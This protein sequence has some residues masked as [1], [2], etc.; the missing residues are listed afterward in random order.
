MKPSKF[1]VV[2]F[3][4]RNGVSSWR[5]SGWLNGDRIRKNFKNRAEAVAEKTTLEVRAAQTEQ[6]M[7]TVATTLTAEEVREAETVFHRLRGR[8]CPLSF[9]VDFALT[10][11]KEPEHRKKLVDAC[12]DYVAAKQR[13]FDQQQLSRSQMRHI[14]WETKRLAAQFPLLSVAEV[15]STALTAYLEASGG[16]MKNH[17]NRRGLLSTFFKFCFMRG[18]TA[19]NPIPKVPHYRIRR[20][21]GAATTLTAAH[22]RKV[23]DFAETY[24]GGALVPF[25]ALCLF[26]GIRPGVPEGEISR[27]T[28]EMVD[29]G[30]CEI[31]ITAE[32]SKVSEPRTTTIQPNLAAWL[33]AYPL[34]GCAVALG[35]FNKRRQA[36]WR[37]LG[38]TQDVMRHTFISMFVAKF[39]SIGEAAIQAGNS[40]AIIRRHYLNLKSKE[41][42]EDFFNILP[43]R[44]AARSSDAGTVLAIPAT[45]IGAA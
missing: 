16:G 17:N 24:E 20:K 1:E 13:E 15:T 43:S 11:Y 10:N 35:D 29:L 45:H 42:A 22:A 33:R 30:K 39:R 38:L 36:M 3:E 44:I 5:V 14:G 4:N 21:R 2:P 7:R 19:E 9:Y 37:I 27:L 12:V 40:E 28:P 6:G 26:A 31:N 25:F 32:V 18:W 41:E 34:E 23:M 8:P